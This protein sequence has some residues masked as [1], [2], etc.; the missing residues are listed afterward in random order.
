MTDAGPSAGDRHR[1]VY[2]QADLYCAAFDFPVGEEVEWALSLAPGAARVLEPMCGNARYAAAFAERG[3]AYT[4]MDRSEAMLARAAGGP[5]IT[6]VIGDARDFRIDAPPFD[7]GWCPIN[8]I[9]HLVTEADV[10]AHLA[11]MREHIVA[12][13][14]YVIETDLA[15]SDARP[16]DAVDGR[17]TWTMPQPDGSNVEACVSVES[18]DLETRV[19]REVAR[20]RRIRDGAVLEE[21]REV[22][23]M[24]MFSLADLRS[25]AASAGFTIE[26]AFRHGPG[27]RRPEVEPGEALEGDGLNYYFVLRE[28]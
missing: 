25:D 6:L 5:G 3:I 1:S 22:F 4:G 12:G 20:Y 26:R 14:A 17:S 11:C 2:T 13:G 7:L 27:G 23:P 15:P 28:S 21:A 19:V 18:A 9:R 10:R 16:A 8:S 24:R